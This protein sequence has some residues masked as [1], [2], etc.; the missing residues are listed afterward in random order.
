MDEQLCITDQ[1]TGFEIS[2]DPQVVAETLRAAGWTIFAPM[3]AQEAMTLMK[4]MGTAPKMRYP[5]HKKVF[6]V[7]SQ[8]HRLLVAYGIHSSIGLTD[9][10]AAG[11]AGLLKSC[12]WKRCGELRDDKLI[13]VL[14]KDG[15]PVAR[16][17]SA[18]T[19]RAVSCITDAG[20]AYLRQL[21][22][23]GGQDET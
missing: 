8:L 20:R 14:Y 17:G 15:L 11:R 13:K 6:R 9:E 22:L 21:D 16:L 7:G 5:Y 2:I 1:K 23:H 3:T 18:G 19:N 4:S 12:Y 10:E